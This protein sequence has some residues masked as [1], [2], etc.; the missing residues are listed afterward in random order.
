MLILHG[1]TQG[2][3]PV[4]LPLVMGSPVVRYQSEGT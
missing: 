3:L 4:V 1:T 2:V